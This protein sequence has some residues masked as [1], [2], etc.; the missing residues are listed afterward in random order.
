M[1]FWLVLKLNMLKDFG[2][3][4][5]DCFEDYFCAMVKYLSF[6]NF[7]LALKYIYI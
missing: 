2:F 3:F 4:L 6:H 1:I 5:E 7:S